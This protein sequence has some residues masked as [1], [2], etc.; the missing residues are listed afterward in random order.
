MTYI[1]TV[2]EGLCDEDTSDGLWIDSLQLNTDLDALSLTILVAVY[3]LDVEGASDARLSTHDLGD[4]H[5]CSCL[6][7]VRICLY[8]DHY[9]VQMSYQWL[10]IM[11][12]L[13]DP[14]VYMSKGTCKHQYT[15]FG[16]FPQKWVPN[17][18]LKI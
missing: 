12:C 9:L 4:V 13:N 5:G 1:D 18:S 15:K 7:R 6:E 10:F 2:F 8:E 16:V 3:F 14:V 17:F 11:K